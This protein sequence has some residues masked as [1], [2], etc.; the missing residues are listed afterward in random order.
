MVA[1]VTTCSS[2][3]V[4]SCWS[5]PTTVSYASR[6]EPPPAQTTLRG[7]F[8]AFLAFEP[9]AR[10]AP[11]ACFSAAAG[12]TSAVRPTAFSCAPVAFDALLTPWVFPAADS[13]TTRSPPS[14]GSP[15]RVRS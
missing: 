4:P 3:G 10:A 8:S 9:S 5:P 12:A 6:G 13:L 11:S 7:A 2:F 14:T 15:S 1:S